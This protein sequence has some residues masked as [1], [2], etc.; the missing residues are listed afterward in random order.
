M[1]GTF[2]QSAGSLDKYWVEKRMYFSLEHPIIIVQSAGTLDMVLGLSRVSGWMGNGGDI[3]EPWQE[4]GH[5]AIT[6]CVYGATTAHH[7]YLRQ[8]QRVR[9]GSMTKTALR[10]RR[11]VPLSV[12]VPLLTPHRLCAEWD[13]ILI[14]GHA[15]VVACHSCDN[16]GRLNAGC[17]PCSS[18]LASFTCIERVEKIPYKGLLIGTIGTNEMGVYTVIKAAGMERGIWE[19]QE[20]CSL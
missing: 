9:R 12:K 18:T 7:G 4:G 14:C 13:K 15:Y 11:P 3:R 19:R 17:R 5:E 2:L 16:A 8:G 10:A 1:F 6:L 20:N